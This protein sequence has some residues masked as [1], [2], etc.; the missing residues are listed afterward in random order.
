MTKILFICT[1]LLSLNVF[2]MDLTLK[3]ANI[4]DI[5][6]VAVARDTSFGRE[7]INAYNLELELDYEQPASNYE[8]VG[9]TIDRHSE[10]GV[11]QLTGYMTAHNY[12]GTQMVSI[13]TLKSKL[14]INA[15]H[16]PLIKVSGK[17]FLFIPAL[18]KLILQSN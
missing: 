3:E 8:Y 14:W 11:T 16:T 2:S 10:A 13:V 7:K 9:R 12:G 17:T 1:I 4:T 15:D 6:L 5:R 18:E